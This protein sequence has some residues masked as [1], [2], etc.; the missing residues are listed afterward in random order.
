MSPCQGRQ[1]QQVQQV[2][3][4]SKG[5]QGHQELEGTKGLR[6]IKAHQGQEGSKV[7]L[8]LLGVKD[9]LPHLQGTYSEGCLPRGPTP[10]KGAAAAA[11][12]QA[13]LALALEQ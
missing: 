10:L 11:T 7:R 5:L 1:G 8:G 2:Q 13:L 6:A 4:V 3:Q 9:L 12:V